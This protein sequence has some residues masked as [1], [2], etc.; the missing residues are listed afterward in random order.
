MIFVE[1]VLLTKLKI[2][3]NKEYQINDNTDVFVGNAKTY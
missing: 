3:V 2:D 1:R